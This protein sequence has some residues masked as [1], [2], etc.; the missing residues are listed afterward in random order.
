[1]AEGLTPDFT[2]DA[3]A[4]AFAAGLETLS[5][6]LP[7]GIPQRSLISAVSGGPDSM[8]L[9]GLAQEYA[10]RRG[11]A[12]RAIIID[13]GIRP[14]AAAEAA[15]VRS[16]L[17]HLGIRA[18]VMK[19]KETAPD[20]GIQA[21]ARSV[22]YTQLV[23]QAR[24]DRALLLLGHHRDDQAET[25]LMRLSR[26]SGL[27]GLAAMRA[28][29]IRE[30]VALLRPMLGFGGELARRYCAARDIIYE[31]DPSNVDRRFERVR[32]R[33]WLGGPTPVTGADLLRLSDAA[34]RIDDTLVK[35][36]RS[37]GVLPPPQPGG[38]MI[39]PA[40]SLELADVGLVRL[41]A[42]VTGQLTAAAH[43]PAR[44][45]LVRLAARL[46]SAHAST[47]GG[48]RF[49]RHRGDW[50]VTAEEGRRPLHRRLAAGD[51]VIFAGT[52]RVT[53]PVAGV[54]R[55]LGERGSG[56]GAPWGESR[57]WANLPALARRSVPVVETLDGTLLYPHLDSHAL[58][59]DTNDG[60]VAEFLP[61]TLVRAEEM[62]ATDQLKQVSTGR[63][64]PRV[65]QP[66]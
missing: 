21:W 32:L 42:H 46:R 63:A 27:S 7:T 3:V 51:V 31:T 15:R 60:A 1:M 26:G 38:H 59:C 23:E 58:S 39:L 35:A 54:V 14:G 28:V 4:T 13:H 33:Q 6:G 25:V 48:V 29:T 52:W 36:F 20:S 61:F 24:R 12:H 30:G 45:A 40:A 64:L 9:A 50:L 10:A 66:V 5:A 49:T 56:A 55:R 43:P 62:T 53:S 34:S 2:P 17:V 8:C 37:H 44:T 47:L 11:L 16:R 65:V 57:G 41:L 19:I 18:D 22:R